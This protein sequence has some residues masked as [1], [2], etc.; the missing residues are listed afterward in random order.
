[1]NPILTR[2]LWLRSAA[3]TAFVAATAPW[4]SLSFA[5]AGSP[6][7][8]RMVF[9]ILRGGM[10]GLYAV[11]ALGDPAFASARG[12]LGEYPSPPLAL[13]ATFSLH[14]ALLGLHAMYRAQELAVVHAVGMPYH[15]RSHFDAQQVLESGGDRPYQYKDGWLGRAL[16][17]TRQKGLA[18]D[19]AVP[20]ALRGLT[21]VDTWAPSRLPDPSNDLLQRLG[22][23]YEGDADLGE[24][25]ARA[26]GMR[27]GDAMAGDGGGASFVEL[28]SR[29][30]D[31]LAL[32]QGPQAAVLELGRWDTHADQGGPHSKLAENLKILDSGLAAL[33]TG[34]S[35][36]ASRGSWGRTVVVVSTEFGRT[37]EINGTRGTDHGTGG[38]GFVLG[39]AVRG[40]RVVADWPGLAKAQRFE[41]RDLKVTTD[42]R[43]VWKGVLGEHLGVTEANLNQKIFPGTQSLKGLSLL[44]A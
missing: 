4:S 29:A 17:S 13:D 11:P 23:L 6:S 28:C 26:R 36:P 18:V 40:G 24:A 1:M 44:K 42:W 41:G 21:Q 34:L 14:P 33:K 8:N 25:L 27:S 19:T 22:K 9:V 32:P 15:E 20:L 39:G 30:A 37:V 38:A 43:A 5:G 7:G 2:R 16:E 31:F 35:A 12:E 3:S 10:D